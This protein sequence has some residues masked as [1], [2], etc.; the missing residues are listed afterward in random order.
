MAQV[1]LTSDLHLG[2][3]NLI[4]SHLNMSVDKHLFL[5]IENWNNV[6]KKEDLV[7]ILG[8]VAMERYNSCVDMFFQNTKGRKYLIA[9]N[10]DNWKL[11]KTLYDNSFIQKIYG[12]LPYKGFLL[13]HCPIEIKEIID[14]NRQLCRGNIHGHIHDL[15][16]NKRLDS[17]FYY[18]VN[19]AFHDFKP[20][21]FTDI[22]EHFKTLRNEI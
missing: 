11:I 7:Y 20:V 5:L 17:K 13:T 19:I 4:E 2:H 8:D 12:C 3:K 21:K 15:E 22:E 16:K 9:G 14:G 1:F 6:V 18:N 10:H